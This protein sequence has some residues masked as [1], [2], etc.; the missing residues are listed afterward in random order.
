M[1]NKSKLINLNP[2]VKLKELYAAPKKVKKLTRDLAQY[3]AV[4]ED[5]A[6]ELLS[7]NE[8]L[9]NLQES[10]GS[11]V[12]PI[13]KSTKTFDV[14]N[15]LEKLTDS[16]ALNNQHM[17]SG[18]N[19]ISQ[20][21]KIF[22]L[23]D[24]LSNS[25]SSLKEFADDVMLLADDFEKSKSDLSF[26][27]YKSI[28]NK[29]ETMILGGDAASREINSS[30]LSNLNEQFESPVASYKSTVLFGSNITHQDVVNEFPDLARAY[31]ALKSMDLT[32]DKTDK[33]YQERGL[34]FI[35]K[36]F[37]KEGNV[38]SDLAHLVKNSVVEDTWIES[39]GHKRLSTAF[40]NYTHSINE[41]GEKYGVDVSSLIAEK[42]QF[43]KNYELDVD[44][45]V[46][47]NHYKTDLF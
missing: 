26:T 44:F 22:S 27:D 21:H 40:N 12:Y 11:L 15:G 35:R 10:Y 17:V 18:Q 5:N 9:K 1:S 33:V 19:L 20:A 41:L 43:A 29:V 45:A 24:K 32:S 16:Y 8:S 46:L 34:F 25:Y 42:E 2:F 23:D 38:I 47:K 39:D 30:G 13:V 7:A 6:E 28:K 14:L 4:E 37:Q 36:E 31:T 3:Q